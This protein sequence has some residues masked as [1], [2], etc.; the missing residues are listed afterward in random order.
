MIHR[1]CPVVFSYYTF[2]KDDRLIYYAN[3]Q[4]AIDNLEKP[5]DYLTATGHYATIVG[6]IK[7]FDGNKIKYLLKVASNGGLYYVNYDKYSEKISWF[8]NILEYSY[9]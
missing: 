4:D 9:R 3:M 8:S 2:I 6:Y 1:N 7:Y 5:K